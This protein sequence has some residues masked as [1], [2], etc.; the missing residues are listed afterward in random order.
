MQISETVE[1]ITNFLFIGKEEQ[2]LDQY[3]LVL[4]LGNNQIEE[5]ID[6]ICML[7]QTKHILNDSVIVFSGNV[8]SL[9]SNSEPE[10]HRLIE[11]IKRRN[12]ITF[13][14][15]LIEDKATNTLENFQLSKTLIEEKFH[16]DSFKKILCVCK[17]FLARRAKMSAA[18]CGYPIEIIDF[19][20]TVYEKG[21]NI[22]PNTWYQTEVAKRRVIEEVKRIAEYTLKG[23]ISLN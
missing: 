8:G 13:Q 12:I 5:T 15:M 7:I 2:Q 23:D 10:A 14:K 22:G 1:S 4:V 3:D 17:A 21:K 20:G 19:Y 18:A 6:D 11:S 16:L 9:S